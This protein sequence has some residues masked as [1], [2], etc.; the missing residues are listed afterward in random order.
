MDIPLIRFLSAVSA[1][2]FSLMTFFSNLSLSFFR[3]L[4]SFFFNLTG[5][6]DSPLAF[7]DVEGRLGFRSVGCLGGFLRDGPSSESFLS[8]HVIVR[9]QEIQEG[10]REGKRKRVKRHTLRSPS[11]LTLTSLYTLSGRSSF[12]RNLRYTL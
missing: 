1:F 3:R 12:I 7:A 8:A 5:L 9:S 10:D 4:I 11:L 6:P 2:S